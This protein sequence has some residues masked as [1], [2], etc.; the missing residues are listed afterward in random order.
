MIPKSLRKCRQCGAKRGT[1]DWFG[2]CPNPKCV[3]SPYHL[4]NPPPKHKPWPGVPAAKCRQKVL[5][6][7]LD[8]LAGQKDLFA[9]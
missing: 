6:T 9:T 5:I 3:E 8:L 4:A 7:G 2:P 1:K